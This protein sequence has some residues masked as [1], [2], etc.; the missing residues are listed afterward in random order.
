MLQ[1]PHPP[2]CLHM[3]ANEMLTVRLSKSLEKIISFNIHCRHSSHSENKL[4]DKELH[5]D[6]LKNV[7]LSQM[8]KP[9]RHAAFTSGNHNFRTAK[10]KLPNSCIFL[11]QKTSQDQNAQVKTSPI[12]NVVE[13]CHQFHFWVCTPFKKKKKKKISHVEMGLPWFKQY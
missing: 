8:M 9:A 13:T 12:Q 6:R 4:I 7:F 3:E 5:I 11:N 1:I 2:K 10:I